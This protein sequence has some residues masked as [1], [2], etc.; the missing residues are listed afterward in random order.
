MSN[1]SEAMKSLR[2]KI[3][4][5]L[6]LAAIN[7]AA[8][9]QAQP[10]PPNRASIS[11]PVTADNFIRAESDAVFTGL[12][13]QGGFG[14][15]YHNRELTPIDSRIVQRANRDTLYSTGVFD[16]DAGPVTITLPD[17]GKRF[18][19]MIVIDEDHY[20]DGSPRRRAKAGPSPS[21]SAA[22]TE[23]SRTVYQRCW[24]GTIWC[25]SIARAPKS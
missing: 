2:L 8:L 15:F 6:L 12:V 3:C 5:C 20:V 25:A 22:A 11:V 17:A 23:R 18:M 14:K 16:L 21:S 13:A 10:A 4:A 9:V 19:T 24:A 1:E 7:T